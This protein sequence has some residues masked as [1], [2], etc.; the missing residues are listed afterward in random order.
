MSR[1]TQ[2]ENGEERI[3]AKSKPVR[4]LVSRRR[5]GSSIVPISTTSAS[6][7]SFRSESHELDLIASTG[8][9]VAPCQKSE[10]NEGDKMWNSQEWQTDARSMASTG[11]PVA[12]DSNQ[13][14]DSKAGTE[15]TRFIEFGH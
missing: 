14:Q 4:S 11:E 12:W 10:S 2:E 5:A 15:G 13:M 3:A 7:V 6:L 9:P 1:R 8:R